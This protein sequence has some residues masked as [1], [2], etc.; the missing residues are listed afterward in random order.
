MSVT[1][2]TEEQRH[3]IVVTAFVGYVMLRQG[4]DK[5]S[6]LTIVGRLCAATEELISAYQ[7]PQ[8]KV[9]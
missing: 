2:L 3:S 6:A 1:E 4:C 9:N 5:D 8:E 7:H